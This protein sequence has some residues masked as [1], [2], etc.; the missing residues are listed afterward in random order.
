MMSHLERAGCRIVFED[1]G[2]APPPLVLVH[3]WCCNRR[4]L[5]PQRQHFCARHRVIPLD[6]PGHG[7]SD[8]PQRDYSIPAFA[9][10]L[11]WLC[12]ELD[13]DKPVIIGHSMGG[14]IALELAADW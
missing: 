14:A 10:D 5:E 2:G 1:A 11:A 4:F 13:L 6:L 7:D 8:A 9:A 3:G 12:E